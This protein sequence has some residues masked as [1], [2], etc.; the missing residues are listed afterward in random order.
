MSSHVAVIAENGGEAHEVFTRRPY[1]VNAAR[2]VQSG[3]D[4]VFGFQGVLADEVPRVADFGRAIMHAEITPFPGF[5]LKYNA[6]KAGKLQEGAEE[7]VGLRG[8]RQMGHRPFADDGDHPRS[9][10]AR[11]AERAG[12]EEQPVGWIRPLH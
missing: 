7:A 5:A 9:R 3:T 12:K 1:S 6:V 4:R 11:A 2:P 10:I 8:S